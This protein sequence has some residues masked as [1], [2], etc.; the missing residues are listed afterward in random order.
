MPLSV[1]LLPYGFIHIRNE[2][3]VNDT[4]FVFLVKLFLMADFIFVFFALLEIRARREEPRS[5]S[6]FWWEP[7]GLVPR[8]P[9]VEGSLCP[10]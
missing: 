10:A 5:L 6:V 7:T 3:P 8:G 9:G 2:F 4:P 1:H